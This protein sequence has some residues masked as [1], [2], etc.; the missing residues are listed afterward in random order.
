MKE[1]LKTQLVSDKHAIERIH[2]A[3]GLVSAAS[4][5]ISLMPRFRVFVHSLAPFCGVVSP[6]YSIL[7][8]RDEATYLEL[9]VMARL[10]HEIKQVLRE[11]FVGHRPGSRCVVGHLDRGLRGTTIVEGR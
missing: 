10:L 1:D 2:T 8:H 5:M 11:L 7:P 3:S 9:L 6:L 4:I